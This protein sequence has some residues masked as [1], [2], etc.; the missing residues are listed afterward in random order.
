M[1]GTFRLLEEKR[2]P[3]GLD[4]AVDDLRDLEI[5]IDLGGYAN[6]LALALEQ[7]DPFA[8]VLGRH[9]ASLRTRNEVPFDLLDEL[10]VQADQAFHELEAEVEVLL[11]VRQRLGAF[12]RLLHPRAHVLEVVAQR[13]EALAHRVFSDEVRRQSAK[14]RLALERGV[15]ERRSHPLA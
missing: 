12:G 11:A 3:A 7:R 8:E 14:E 5:R 4:G 15:V 2:R 1:L 9:G 13:G 6:E 10:L